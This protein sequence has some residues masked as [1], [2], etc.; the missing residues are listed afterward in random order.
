MEEGNTISKK[1]FE[2][3]DPM[4]LED[5]NKRESPQ[6]IDKEKLG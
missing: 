1:I 2:G 6:K 4:Y 3:I 5:F